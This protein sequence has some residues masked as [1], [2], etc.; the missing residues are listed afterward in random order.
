MANFDRVYSMKLM[1]FF[2]VFL[3]IKAHIL[4]T[5]R[6]FCEILLYNIQIFEI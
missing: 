5:V 2:H 3:F 1:H 6:C 4:Y